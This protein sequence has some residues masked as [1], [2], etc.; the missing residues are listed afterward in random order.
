M[1]P[2]SAWRQRPY[3]H[4]TESFLPHWCS[5]LSSLRNAPGTRLQN[6][7]AWAFGVSQRL[8]VLARCCITIF[9]LSNAPNPVVSFYTPFVNTLW[10]RIHT[11]R[12]ITEEEENDLD[13]CIR[14][15]PL[16]T[17]AIQEIPFWCKMGT[18]FLQFGFQGT[19]SKVAYISRRQMP[20]FY[21]IRCFFHI[22]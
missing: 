19:S 2:P 5:W 13:P 16:T 4:L 10:I 14:T 8:L 22:R 17:D 15:R 20:R 3:V 11:D 6:N 18:G 1:N 7:E 12:T 21:V 9:C